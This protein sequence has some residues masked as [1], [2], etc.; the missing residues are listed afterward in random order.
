VIAEQVLD[1]S[2]LAAG[3]GYDKPILAEGGTRMEA[4]HNF[5]AQYAQQYASG[6]SLTHL[7]LV[8]DGEL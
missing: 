4:E 5:T 2:W 1:G 6:Q 3:M 7:S 8:M